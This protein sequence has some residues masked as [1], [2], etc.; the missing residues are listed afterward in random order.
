M[1]ALQISRALRENNVTS[2]LFR[3][4]FPADKLPNPIFLDTQSS[5]QKHTDTDSRLSAAYVAN[6]SNASDSGT[7]WVAVYR[8]KLNVIEVWDSSEKTAPILQ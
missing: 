6:C 1:D 2:T 5:D 8:E 3:G 4:V 7:H